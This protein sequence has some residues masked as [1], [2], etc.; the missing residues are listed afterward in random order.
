MLGFLFALV[1]PYHMFIMNYGQR[2]E[3]KAY[4]FI[5]GKRKTPAVKLIGHIQILCR[6]KHGNWKTVNIKLFDGGSAI[7]VITTHDSPLPG[8]LILWWLVRADE[9]SLLF[10]SR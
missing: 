10:S 6:K 2:T 1:I 8:Y 9:I 3:V 5:D 7:L 4:S